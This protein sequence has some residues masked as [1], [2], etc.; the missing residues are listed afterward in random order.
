MTRMVWIGMIL[1]MG[2]AGQTPGEEVKLLGDP[3]QGPVLAGRWLAAGRVRAA[4]VG[5]L[6]GSGDE[7]ER[8]GGA[9]AAGIDGSAGGCDRR[10]KFGDC[11][12]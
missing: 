10:T 6:I 4:A 2:L 11:G 1:A 9:G 3:G 5:G 12:C 8:F 7:V